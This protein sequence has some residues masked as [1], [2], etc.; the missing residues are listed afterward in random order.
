MKIEPNTVVHIDMDA[1]FAQVEQLSNPGLRGKPVIVGF[2]GRRGVVASASYEARKYGVKAGMP[3]FMVD[4]LCPDAI[5]VYPDNAKYEDM[6]F[7]IVEIL[8]PFTPVLEVYSIDEM[9]MNFGYGEIT[10][11]YWESLGRK[12]KKSVRDGTGLRCTVGIGRNKLQAKVATNRAKPDGLGMIL[13]DEFEEIWG[14]LDI[15]ELWGVGQRSKAVLERFGIRKVKDVWHYSREYL[16]HLFGAFGWVLW[17]MAYGIDRSKWVTVYDD[18]IP[19]SVGNSRT[20][21]ENITDFGI[22]KRV[23]LALCMEVSSRMR[24]KKLEGRGVSIAVRYEDFK[25]IT[26]QR[27][28]PYPV[29]DFWKIWH[30]AVELLCEVNPEKPVRLLGVCVWDLCLAESQKFWTEDQK[31]YK[32]IE[33]LDDISHKFGKN[34]VIP[35]ILLS[36]KNLD[37]GYR[38]FPRILV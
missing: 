5:W 36:H 11:S 30:F 4:R 37:K 31:R 24:E 9:F 25:T 32:L 2:H 29:Q 34:T 17:E 35:A 12:I 33:A 14:N 13:P 10:K 20:L 21:N 3:A 15:D 38:P 27:A 16:S 28:L 22:M 6:T 1:Y 7:R 19:K 18:D 26:H 23:L 8:R